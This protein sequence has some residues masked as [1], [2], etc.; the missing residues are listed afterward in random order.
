MRLSAESGNRPGGIERVKEFW[1][2]HFAKSYYLP[3]CP[4]QVR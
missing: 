3:G 4:S 1:V 2:Q